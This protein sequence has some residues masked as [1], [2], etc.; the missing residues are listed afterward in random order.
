MTQE[1][2][3]FPYA[4]VAAF[5]TALKDRFAEIAKS[6]PGYTV[7]ELQP[8]FAYDRA[9]ARSRSPSSP[10]PLSKRSL[11]PAMNPSRDIAMYRTVEDV[12]SLLDSKQASAGRRA[13]P[14]PR[15]ADSQ[16]DS[17]DARK[18]FG[19]DCRIGVTSFVERV[20]GSRSAA[21][22]EGKLR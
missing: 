9:L 15:M 18:N 7:N 8:Q 4:T 13:L 6:G 16:F 10:R 14:S 17:D 19:K 1:V 21:T 22:D 3:G 2:E 5:R 20:R 11:G 12:I